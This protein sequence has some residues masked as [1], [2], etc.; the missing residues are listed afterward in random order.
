MYKRQGH[1]VGDINREYYRSK[2]EEQLWREERD[3]I[4]NFSQLLVDKK[5]STSEE[6]KSIELQIEKDAEEAVNYALNA[7]WPDASEVNMHVF[8]SN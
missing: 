3:P 8:A 1:H 5:I 4:T 6:L 7:A 2:E